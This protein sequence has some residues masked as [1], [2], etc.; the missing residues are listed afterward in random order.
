M[1]LPCGRIEVGSVAGNGTVKLEAI[2]AGWQ[3]GYDAIAQFGDIDLV[4][5][6]FDIS[7]D[8]GDTI[9]VR[10][11]RVTMADGSALL[12]FSLGSAAGGSL[13]V[14]GSESVTLAGANATGAPSL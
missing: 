9:Q 4:N 3:L 11:G 1:R 5:A 14:R 8:G 10:G 6:S 7:G 13:A 12:G 2:A